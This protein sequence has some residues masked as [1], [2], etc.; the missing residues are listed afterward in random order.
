VTA[1]GAQGCGASS[2][3]GPGGPRSFLELPELARQEQLLLGTQWD[4]RCPHGGLQSEQSLGTLKT[5]AFPREAESPR[6]YC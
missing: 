6:P 2:A 4:T 3:Y 5:I 1:E